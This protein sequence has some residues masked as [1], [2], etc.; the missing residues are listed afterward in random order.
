MLDTVNHFSH[1]YGCYHDTTTHFV[2]SDLR[3]GL[4]YVQS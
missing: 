2:V 1:K 3:P 4:E